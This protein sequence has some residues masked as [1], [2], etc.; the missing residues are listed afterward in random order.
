MMSDCGVPLRFISDHQK[1]TQAL[2]YF[3]QKSGGTI[4]K[5]KAIKLIFFAD[6]YHLRKYGRPVLGDDYM[7][8]PYGPVASLAKDLAE[9]TLFLDECERTYRDQFL[10][11]STDSLEIISRQSVDLD[12]FSDSD[13]EALD[14]SWRVFGRF[15]QFKLADIS[16]AY[17]EW[18]KHRESLVGR[19]SCRA[20][21]RYADFFDDPDPSDSSLALLGHKDPFVTAI[22]DEEKAI[23]RERA[24]EGSAI[25]LLWD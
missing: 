24:E 21:M 11:R 2:N 6:R 4:N 9:S 14:F 22:S 7:A 19:S 12:V 10:D 5:L 16:H 18:S 1:A 15:N 23:A 20:T 13:A 25:E 3:A 17:P 8:M